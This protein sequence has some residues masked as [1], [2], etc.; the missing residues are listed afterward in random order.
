MPERTKRNADGAFAR[1]AKELLE[2]GAALRALVDKKERVW[3][4]LQRV[5]RHPEGIETAGANIA[6][7]SA[8]TL[9]GGPMRCCRLCGLTEKRRPGKIPYK[10][11]RRCVAAKLS[12]QAFAEEQLRIDRTIGYAL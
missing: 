5:C 4:K 10:R 3:R 2:T 1:L 11:L 7:M 6:E 9:A 12:H 8:F